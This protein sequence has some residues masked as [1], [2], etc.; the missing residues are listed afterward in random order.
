VPPKD[1]GDSQPM[2]NGGLHGDTM[3]RAEIRGRFLS[4]KKT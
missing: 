2:R 4:I 3:A 1:V